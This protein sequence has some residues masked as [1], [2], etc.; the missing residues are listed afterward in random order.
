MHI[1]AFFF[2]YSYG[3]CGVG[4]LFA[5]LRFKFSIKNESKCLSEN[6]TV[7]YILHALNLSLKYSNLLKTIEYIIIGINIA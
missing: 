3:R 4:R 6:F 1:W 7:L 2:L 5:R